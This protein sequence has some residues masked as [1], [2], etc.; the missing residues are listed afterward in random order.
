MEEREPARDSFSR[1]RSDNS[2]L[3]IPF[4]MLPLLTSLHWQ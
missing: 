2:G 1:S 4:P 3:A